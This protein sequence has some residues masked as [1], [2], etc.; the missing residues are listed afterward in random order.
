[1]TCVCDINKPFEI[2]FDSN[3]LHNVG[4]L[5]QIGRRYRRYK[6]APSRKFFLNKPNQLI[7]F[8]WYSILV[9]FFE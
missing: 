1:M 3:N 5:F 4:D 8:I 9:L 7:Q 2:I 6:R